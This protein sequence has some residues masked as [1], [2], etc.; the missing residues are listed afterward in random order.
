MC[1]KFLLLSLLFFALFYRSYSDDNCD[2]FITF[3][4]DYYCGSG[5]TGT[6]LCGGKHCGNVADMCYCKC[7]IYLLEATGSCKTSELGYKWNGGIKFSNGSYA[8]NGTKGDG[9]EYKC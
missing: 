8:L 4:A 3:E 9:K 1:T 6:P 5:C 7:N 2:K